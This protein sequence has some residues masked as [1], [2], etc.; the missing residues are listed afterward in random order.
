MQLGSTGALRQYDYSYGRFH[1]YP[2][3]WKPPYVACDLAEVHP[4]IY[5]G[6]HDEVMVVHDNWMIWRTPI[7][8]DFKH[9]RKPPYTLYT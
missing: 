4:Q 1:T 9:F 5:C 7:L 8:D 3:L 6:F 2:H